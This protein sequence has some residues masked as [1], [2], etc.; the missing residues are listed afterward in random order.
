MQD[1]SYKNLEPTYYQATANTQLPVVKLTEDLEIDTCVIGAGFSGLS[2]ALELA[3]AGHKVAV[4]EAAQ[5]GFGASGRN[6]GEVL[7]GYSCSMP[8]LIKQL[9]LEAAKQL[10]QLSLEAVELVDQR[11]KEYQ[12]DCHWQRGYVQPAR[13]ATQLIELFE[14]QQLL[15]RHFEFAKY[16]LWDIEKTREQINSQR[17]IGALFDSQSG[18]LQPLNYCLGLAKA[19]IDAGAL[20][21][22][23]S[24]VQDLSKHQ[25][26]WLVSTDH[27]CIKVKNVVIA[28]NAYTSTINNHYF[29]QLFKKLILVRSN[30]AVSQPLGDL[31]NTLLAG[32]FCV[33]ECNHLVDYY[34]ITADQ[35]LLF[36]GESNYWSSQPKWIEKTL[37]HKINDVFPQLNALKFDYSWSGYIDSTANQA[38]HFGALEKNLYFMQGFSG[39]GVALTGLA[40]QAVAQAILGD[41]QRLEQFSIIKHQSLP[42]PVWLKN[43]AGQLAL[44]TWALRDKLN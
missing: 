20:V 14:Q 31:A 17:Y 30:I 39:H 38:P 5:V 34:H 33:S 11:V 25:E 32:K 35:R 15:E 42:G 6:G 27:A 40:G 24:P 28:T 22:Q 29:K 1:A 2:T 43:I 21:F 7:V 19:A 4:V 36:G 16:N 9:G 18:F 26:H 13:T 23:H 41:S 37:R 3:K 12:I 44:H 8:S 10:W